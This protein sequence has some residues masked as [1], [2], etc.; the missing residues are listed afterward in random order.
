MTGEMLEAAASETEGVVMSEIIVA[1]PGGDRER[2]NDHGG[3]AVLLTVAA[4]VAAGI[5]YGASLAS[6]SASESWQ[7]ALRTEVKRSAAAMEDVRYLYQ[8]EL[9]IA[10]RILE[11]RVLQAEMLAEAQGQS[12]A[13]KQGLLL[14]AGIQAEIISAF[15]SSSEL[16]SKPDYALT[17]GG[18]D[19]GKRLADLRAQNPEILALDPDGLETTGDQ[20]ANKAELLTFALMPTSVAAFLG[21]LSQPFR[22][23]RLLLLRLGA[24]ALAGGA[25]MALFVWVTA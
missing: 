13:S 19:L 16:A 6:N 2:H 23:R 18:L 7:S 25:A 17:T 5:G 1:G 22:R 8:A 24:V 3:V 4:I 15:S 20:L 14:E 10:D 11:A 21:V 9:P 12:G